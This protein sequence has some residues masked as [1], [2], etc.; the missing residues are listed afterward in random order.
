MEEEIE[1]TCSNCRCPFDV[2]VEPG[3]EFECPVCGF[4]FENSPDIDL[5]EYFW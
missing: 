5:D 3:Q 4:L 1:I 2:C